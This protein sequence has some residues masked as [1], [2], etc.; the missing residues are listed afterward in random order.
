M[1]QD[2]IGIQGHGRIDQGLAGGDTGDHPADA[3]A[4]LHLQPV[5]TV[6]LDGV[7][8]EQV[9]EHGFQFAMRD[10]RSPL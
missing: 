10:H 3:L 4:P 8:L 5:G 9:I 1:D 2:G 6:V 7:R